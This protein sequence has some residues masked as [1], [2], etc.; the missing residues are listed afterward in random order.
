MS[1]GDV[2]EHFGW[3]V[4]LCYSK[5]FDDAEDAAYAHNYPELELQIFH[6]AK[7]LRELHGFSHGKAVSVAYALRMCAHSPDLM[8]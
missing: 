6:M 1:L 5:A 8:I 7:E 2:I 4:I 3:R